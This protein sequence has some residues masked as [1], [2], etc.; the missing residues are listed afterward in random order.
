MRRRR[1]T[2][3]AAGAVMTNVYDV[4]TAASQFGVAS[5]AVVLVLLAVQFLV[6]PL[7]VFRD[8]AVWLPAVDAPAFESDER[9]LRVTLQADGTIYVGQMAVRRALLRRE[10]SVLAADLG[11]ERTVVLRID[12]RVA[13]NRAAELMADVRAAGYE[14]LF[15][16]TFEGTPMQWWAERGSRE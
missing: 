5:T 6:T 11:R 13:F 3:I 16:L 12:R 10:L 7:C 8:P 2:R 9:E 4:P 15:L 14:E 1:L